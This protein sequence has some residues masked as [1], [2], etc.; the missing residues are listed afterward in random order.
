MSVS[1]LLARAERE[2]ASARLLYEQGFNEACV[3]R[4]Y[5]RMFYAAE[6]MLL[7]HNRTA[8]THRGLITLF[9]RYLVKP[10][11]VPAPYG[12]MLSRAAQKRQVADYADDFV[13]LHEEAVS[14]LA[15]AETLVQFAERF[16][17]N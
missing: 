13:I 7:H 14:I 1:T 2:V 10:G 8:S 4:A 9:A 15:E 6:A 16:C 11:L 12:K 5:Y 3:S 17:A